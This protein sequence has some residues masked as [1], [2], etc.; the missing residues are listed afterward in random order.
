MELLGDM[1]QVAACFGPFGDCINLGTRQVHGLRRL[2]QGM[3]I[4]LAAPNG[5]PR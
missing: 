5:T 3:E 1:G 4:F 2:R